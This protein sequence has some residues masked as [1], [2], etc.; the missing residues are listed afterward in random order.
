MQKLICLSLFVY[1]PLIAQN[2][3]AA[4]RLV[5]QQRTGVSDTAVSSSIS[6]RGAGIDKRI[7]A[8]NVAILHVPEGKADSIKDSL[9]RTGLFNYVEADGIAHGRLTPND[10]MF[11]S[12][13]HLQTIQAPA[14]W[15]LTSGST[16]VAI[17][18]IDSGVDPTHPDL[19]SKL[20]PGWSF[21]GGTANTSDVLGHGTAVAGTAAAASDNVIGVTGV[22]WR[23][24]IM[25]LQVLNA[26]N[27]A[28]YSD[29][30][31]AI[32][33]AADHGA[34]IINISISGTSASSVLQSAVDYA[35]NKGSVVF[36]AAGNSSNNTP[37]YPAACDKVIAVSA[38]DASDNLA[39][40]SNYGTWIDLAAPGS[41]IY[42]TTNGGGYGAWE[43]TSFA[44]P[45]AAAVG[46]LALSINPGLSN[47]A[48]VSMLEQNSDD[49]GPAG[50]DA[51]YGWGR[52]NAYRVASAA[53]TASV[54]DSVPPAISLTS[55]QA[56]AVLSGSV[57]V[58]ASA[59][60]NVGVTQTEL[61]LDGSLIATSSTGSLSFTW[62]TAN[63]ANSSHVLLAKAY[64]L[65]GNVGQA[66][67]T[68]TV[69]N[70]IQADSQPPVV[71][72]MAPAANTRITNTVRISVSASDN[73]AVSQVSV[74]VDGV[75]IG[76]TST[77]PYSVNWNAKKTRSGTHTITATAWDRVGNA[78]FSVPV[79]VFK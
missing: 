39:S 1:L 76:S 32:T 25:P 59:S 66:Q 72:I 35:W 71:A 11:I 58:A 4:S 52:V 12:Q 45:I 24:P 23:N 19:V 22:A 70:V 41:Y 47:A 29:I 67:T 50:Y 62:A 57:V 3:H 42:T 16:A 33:Y 53:A 69:N 61:Y 28:Y 2:E 51:S 68:V 13:W 65:A 34:R 75:L 6:T 38:T 9:M 8:L 17:A 49:L 18:V 79:S 55:P 63:S 10:A 54:I 60:D 78:G 46:A 74:Y 7:A 31:N 27:L 43:G 40:F 77:A 73:V 30:A 15:N 5:V 26:S 37:N 64:D 44:S 20:V 14:A 21:V 48:L 56:N 36:A